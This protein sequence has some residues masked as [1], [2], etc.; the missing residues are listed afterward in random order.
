MSKSSV[1]DSPANRVARGLDELI[2]TSPA[3]FSELGALKD[4]IPIRVPRPMWPSP[5]RRLTHPAFGIQK[6]A[7]GTKMLLRKVSRQHI[8]QPLFARNPEKSHA[9]C[10]YLSDTPSTGT[11]S[12]ITATTIW[13]KISQG[14]VQKSSKTI[15][16][17]HQLSTNLPAN[18]IVLREY[19]VLCAAPRP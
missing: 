9:T 1:C 6:V 2:A 18:R 10:K 8:G 3:R 7:I 4:S 5:S 16:L 12:Q 14:I 11:G 17:S 13:T 15:I 19:W